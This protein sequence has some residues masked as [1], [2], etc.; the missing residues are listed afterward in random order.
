[1]QIVSLGESLHEMSA[2]FLEKIKNIVNLS[3]TEYDQKGVNV[4]SKRNQV[5]HILSQVKNAD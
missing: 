5:D 2:Y 1:M 4:K 3:F